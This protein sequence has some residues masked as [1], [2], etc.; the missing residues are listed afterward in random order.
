MEVTQGA[1]GS[2]FEVMLQRAL[3]DRELT[4]TTRHTDALAGKIATVDTKANFIMVGLGVILTILLS[5]YAATAFFTWRM[6]TALL[7]E[8]SS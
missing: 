6:V 8:L 1:P 4:V 5:T 7:A 2:D 3:V